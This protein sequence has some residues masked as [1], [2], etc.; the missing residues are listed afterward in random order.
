[1]LMLTVGTKMAAGLMVSIAMLAGTSHA[2]ESLIPHDMVYIGHGLSIMGMDKEEPADSGKTLTAYDKR[3]KGPWSA[4]A[5]N[6]E[7]PAHMVFLDS[8]LIDRYEVSNKDY[9]NFIKTQGHPAPAYWDDPRLNTPEQPVAGVNWTRPRRT[10][11]I[12]GSG[13]RRKR[14]GKRLLVA[15]MAVCFRGAMNRRHQSGQTLTGNGKTSTHY[16]RWDL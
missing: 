7:G 10:V 3:M 2:K 13:S 16:I 4:E 15:P 1:M 14:N 9:G 12:E 6:D 11:N 8:F 5:F